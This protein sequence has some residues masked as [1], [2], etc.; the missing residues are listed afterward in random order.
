LLREADEGVYEVLEGAWQGRRIVGEALEEA[1]EG[2]VVSHRWPARGFGFGAIDDTAL[3]GFIRSKAGDFS[4]GFA[5]DLALAIPELAEPWGDPYLA[6]WQKGFQTGERF[7]GVAIGSAATFVTVL[8]GG[9]LVAVVVVGT[10]VSVLWNALVPPTVSA[11]F[12]Y[13]GQP[14]PYQ[15]NRRLQP[16]E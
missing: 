8:S 7:L 15:R 3:K 12:Q 4:F 10:G 6:P 16:L 9:G 5:V 14:D 1:L 2:A 13:L 11:I